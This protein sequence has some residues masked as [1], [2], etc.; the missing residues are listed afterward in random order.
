MARNTTKNAER[1]IY[2]ESRSGKLAPK[3]EAKRHPSTVERERIPSP[4]SADR[5]RKTTERASESLK[6]LAKR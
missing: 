1:A 2:R 6:R 4:Q 3:G 5:I